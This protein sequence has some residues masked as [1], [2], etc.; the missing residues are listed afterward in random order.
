M[1]NNFKKVH[2]PVDLI[3]SGV[4]LLAGIGIFFVSKW[5]GMAVAL[6]GLLSFLVYKSGW[7]REGDETPLQHR[8]VEVSRNCKT[9]LM[10]FLEGKNEEPDVRHGNEGGTLLLEVWYAPDLSKSYV[11]LSEY[12]ELRFQKI[13]EIVELNESATRKLLSKL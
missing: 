12:M 1:E 10:E 4:I 11:Q 6:C 3:I 13:T 9:S 7:K 5:G 2:T 8:T